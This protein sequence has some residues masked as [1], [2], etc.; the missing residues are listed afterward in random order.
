MRS[1]MTLR[2]VLLPLR[3][4]LVDYLKGKEIKSTAND[5]LYDDDRLIIVDIA[6]IIAQLEPFRWSLIQLLVVN[7]FFAINA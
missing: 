2:K 3:E 7:V 6:L 5:I 1:S 4:V